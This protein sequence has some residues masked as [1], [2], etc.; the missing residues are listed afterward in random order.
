MSEIDALLKEERRFPPPP[1]WRSR[2]IV[3]DAAIYDRAA[4]NP[5]AFWADFARELEWMRPWTEVVAL[6]PAERAV[7]RRRQAERERQLSRSPRA[8][9]EEKQGRASSGKGSPATGAR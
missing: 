2:A 6:E 5:E 8:H 9:R 3:S 7:V 4:A 1:E